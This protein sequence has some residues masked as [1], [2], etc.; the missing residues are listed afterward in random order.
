M[1]QSAVAALWNPALMYQQQADAVIQTQVP[2]IIRRAAHPPQLCSP[3]ASDI[4]NWV[5]QGQGADE[6]GFGNRVGRGDH[7]GVRGDGRFADNPPHLANGSF[8]HAGP[9]DA[10]T[11]LAS[12]TQCDGVTPVKVEYFLSFKDVT[13]GLSNVIFVG[14]MHV[15]KA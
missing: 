6:G 7:A 8:S 11:G 10:G 3:D 1:E 5:Y 12:W 15:R 2:F 13:D 9:V 4:D 14:E